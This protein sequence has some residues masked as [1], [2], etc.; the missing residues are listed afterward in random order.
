MLIDEGINLNTVRQLVGYVD[1]R[2]TLNNYCLDRSTADE[3]M[4]LMTEALA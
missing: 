3:K 2:T 4:R 1:E